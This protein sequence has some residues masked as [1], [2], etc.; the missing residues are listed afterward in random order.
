MLKKLSSWRRVPNSTA[1]S[2]GDAMAETIVEARTVE[3]PK[4]DDSNPGQTISSRLGPFFPEQSCDIS[5]LDWAGNL[6]TIHT[7]CVLV[8]LISV[9]HC[10]PHGQ[11]DLPGHYL[12]THNNAALRA[13]ASWPELIDHPQS[14]RSH[15]DSDLQEREDSALKHRFCCTGLDGDC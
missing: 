11:E 2:C 7:F 3:R 5:S 1:W 9:I 10:H 6:L 14:H 12:I 4:P 13:E 15:R 8:P